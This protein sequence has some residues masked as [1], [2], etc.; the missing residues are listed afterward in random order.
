VKQKIMLNFSRGPSNVVYLEI[1]DEDELSGSPLHLS[2]AV[3][4]LY[5]PLTN[6]SSFHSPPPPQSRVNQ[7]SSLLSNHSLIHQGISCLNSTT[8]RQNR[9]TVARVLLSK[10]FSALVTFTSTEESLMLSLSSASGTKKKKS[11]PTAVTRDL[12][13]LRPWGSSL[14]ISRFIISVT[15]THSRLTHVLHYG[16]RF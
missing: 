11:S 10:G 4:G 14:E 15:P 1:Q 8:V 2:D 5:M 6:F 16:R 7:N 12:R 9:E 3:Q 13:A